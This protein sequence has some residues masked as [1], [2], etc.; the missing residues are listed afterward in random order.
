MSDTTPSAVTA[1][2]P[3]TTVEPQIGANGT[4]PP[5]NGHRNG[6]RQNG[7]LRP[8]KR[9]TDRPRLETWLVALFFSVVYGVVGYFMLTDAR[10]VDF[11]SLQVLNNAYTAWWNSPPKLAAIPLDVAPFDSLIYMPL[12]LI[13]PLATSLVA[14]PVAT[15]IA[16]GLLMALLN[17][18]MARCEFPVWM[19]FLF[20]V[21]F[22]LN[23]MFVYYAGNGDPTVLGMMFAGMAL[24][25]LISW[26][27]SHET[28]FLALG[29]LAMAVAVMFDYGYF[30]WALGIGLA[31]M[32]VGS[33]EEHEEDRRRSALFVFLTPPVYALS[34]WILIQTA[35]L[36]SPFGWISA[37]SGMIQ[38]NTS[39]ALDAIGATFGSTMADLGEV[40]L[41]IAPLAFL[42]VIL[43]VAVGIVKRSGLAWGLLLIL[44]L[45][46]AVPVI[47]ALVADQASLVGLSVGLPIAMAALFSAA[48]VYRSEESWRVGVA[49]VIGIGLIAALPLGWNAM[50]EYQFQN[51]AQAF[52]R[53]VEDRETQEGTRSVGDYS[54]GLDPEIAMASYINDS[55]PQTEG[56][57]LVDENFSYGPMILSGRPTLFADRADEGEAE[58]EAALDN[59]FGTVDYMLITISR[60][61]D[62]LRKRY[63]EAITGGEL[64]ITP[65]FRTE[66]YMLLEVSQS[67]PP[68]EAV[69]G[70]GEVVPSP[71]PTPFTPQKPPDP[72]APEA[73]TAVPGTAP[74]P[75]VTPSPTPTPATGPG[76]G[77]GASAPQIE[78]E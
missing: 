23:P 52:T 25:S 9:G 16:A 15:A 35:L 33:T 76:P 43:L 47:R 65:I 48:W 50:R 51:Q 12:A 57:I 34:I 22:G 13:K 39:G 63:P 66:R 4:V 73:S 75:T 5:L 42:A 19:R 44:L 20:L 72:S 54:V 69:A 59:P 46:A 77:G 32:F 30:L 10:I 11:D 40:V 29:G 64:G 26:G 49:I 36:G 53:W 7:E 3:G 17:S 55:L 2:P 27:V 24:L 62:Q 70:P 28:R 38:V 58:W 67:R 8:V 21:L 61:G 56:S 68:A 71:T 14:L 60:G 18:T 37:R 1:P 6:D 78:G 31:I 74:E 45:A 41:G